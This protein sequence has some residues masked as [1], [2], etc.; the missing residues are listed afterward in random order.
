MINW[1]SGEYVDNVIKKKRIVLKKDGE[2]IDIEDVL[3]DMEE[4]LR[5][6]KTDKFIDLDRSLLPLARYISNSHAEVYG[7]LKGFIL[8]SRFASE[9]IG[10]T[11]KEVPMSPHE[12]AK[13]TSLKM[14][15][16]DFEE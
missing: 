15:A 16:Y 13:L 14:G 7:F 9:H 1:K 2:E 4:T 11:T 5:E 12:R 6:Y 3:S 10:V 8:G